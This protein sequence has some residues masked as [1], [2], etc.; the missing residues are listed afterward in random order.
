VE[1][2]IAADEGENQDEICAE[3]EIQRGIQVGD[4]P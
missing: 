2:L 4:C 3:M 1:A